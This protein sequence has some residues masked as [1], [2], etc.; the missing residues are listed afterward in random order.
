M[1]IAKELVRLGAKVI[2]TGRDSVKLEKVAQEIGPTA[3][4]ITADA[5]KVSELEKL[6]ETVRQDF[7]H[8][9]IV[10]ANAGGGE[11]VALGS[12]TE[13]HVDRAFDTN[14]K[15]V[16]FTVQG[17]LPLMRQGGSIVI[18]GSTAAI[19]PSAGMSVYGA[20]K[21]AVRNLVSAW[22]QEIKGSGIRSCSCECA[23]TS[24]IIQSQS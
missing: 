24:S 17:A 7:S 10:V 12:I 2:I 3:F 13:E 21:A 20:T 15:G 14:V 22:I 6:Y 16:I 4:A 9:D 18:I 23:S 5:A 19:R 1:A 8:L 11:I